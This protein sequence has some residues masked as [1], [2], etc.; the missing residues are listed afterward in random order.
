MFW[1]KEGTEPT[2]KKRNLLKLFNLSTD[3]EN[4]LI[5]RMTDHYVSKG[6]VIVRE[7]EE[8]NSIYFVASGT[9][10]VRKR[11]SLNQEVEV[12]QMHAGDFFGEVSLIKEQPRSA[13]VI[14]LED[15][16]LFEIQKKRSLLFLISSIPSLK[17]T[18]K[19]ACLR[20]IANDKV[21][22][23]SSTD[24]NHAASN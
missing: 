16:K 18:L 12:A 21:K 3:I 4:L 19:Q 7:G 5:E 13:T 9:L 2:H 1:N 23:H 17:D 22:L 15:A 6:D 20:R 11:N 8:G 14:A 24:A 10:A